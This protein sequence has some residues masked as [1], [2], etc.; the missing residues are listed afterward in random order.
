MQCTRSCLH[1]L[2]D[3]SSNLSSSRAFRL[4]FSRS[5]ND[6]LCSQNSGADSQKTPW[7]KKTNWMPWFRTKYLSFALPYD[8][9]NVR[10][11][12]R[13]Q[14][15]YFPSHP[16]GIRRSL[17]AVVATSAA[18]NL[19]FWSLFHIRPTCSARSRLFPGFIVNLRP[20]TMVSKQ[21][22]RV[23]HNS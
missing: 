14:C 13:S 10:L 18:R 6:T 19:M 11:S 5:L 4:T 21:I 16:R 1:H 23:F 3:F 17:G 8:Y 12:K 7:T 20:T 9:L 22:R 15:K 2:L